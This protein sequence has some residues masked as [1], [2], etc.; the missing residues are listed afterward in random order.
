MRVDI[1]SLVTRA[2]KLC[3]VRPVDVEVS[4]SVALSDED[5]DEDDGALVVR[6]RVRTDVWYG[7]G[8]NRKP[9]IVRSSGRTV[10]DALDELRIAHAQVLSD[11]GMAP[12]DAAVKLRNEVAAR[13]LQER[14]KKKGRERPTQ[15]RGSV[16]SSGGRARRR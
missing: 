8:R 3:D 16:T 9:W 14:R 5:E 7:R 13:R 4:F 11:A 1:R 10:A 15:S 6:L 12:F 2:T